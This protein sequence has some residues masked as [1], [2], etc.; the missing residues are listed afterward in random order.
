MADRRRGA[1]QHT[2][3][4]NERPVPI[5]H[6]DEDLIARAK[7]HGCDWS[8][9]SQVRSDTKRRDRLIRSNA[10]GGVLVIRDAATKERVQE[11][12]EQDQRQGNH[13]RAI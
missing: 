8:L 12:P 10:Q 7:V 3:R 1:V 5:E 4:V 11:R 2:R 13:G 6:L 9:R